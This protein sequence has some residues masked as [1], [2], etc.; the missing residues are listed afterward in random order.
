[1]RPF[2]TPD[3]FMR[4]TEIV[5]FE[6]H[7]HLT[8][9][10]RCC[11]IALMVTGSA[12]SARSQEVQKFDPALDQIVPANAALERLA[13]LPQYNSSRGALDEWKDAQPGHC[14]S[15]SDGAL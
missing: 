15:A 3:S 6:Q 14:A 8:I 5:T 7:E 10:L 12:T 2:S 9:L 1:L 4:M 11:L 13:V